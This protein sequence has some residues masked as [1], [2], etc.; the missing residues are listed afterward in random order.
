MLQLVFVVAAGRRLYCCTSCHSESASSSHSSASSSSSPSSSSDSSSSSTSPSSSS[1]SEACSRARAAAA[2]LASP[3]PG[4]AGIRSRVASRRARAAAAALGRSSEASAS[5]AKIPA[6]SPRSKS[7][8]SE[9]RA[10]CCCCRRRNRRCSWRSWARRASSAGCSSRRSLISERG[11]KAR[12]GKAA[13]YTSPGAVSVTSVSLDLQRPQEPLAISPTSWHRLQPAVPQNIST[14]TGGLAAE[15][16]S[17]GASVAGTAVEEKAAVHLS[18]EDVAASAPC[19]ASSRRRFAS[20]SVDPAS[21]AAASSEA[22]A[23]VGRQRSCAS[24]RA[25]IGLS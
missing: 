5:S 22:A 14:R 8:S 20:G 4:A 23:V 2:I 18:A 19:S 1:S 24:R 13:S 10:I 12:R 9:Y 11:A 25:L 15:P 21:A 16:A 7:R 3:A 6:T 17:Q